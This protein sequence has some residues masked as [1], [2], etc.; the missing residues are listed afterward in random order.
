M[1][2]P[3]PSVVV[4][5]G[6]N[7]AGKST[8]APR[9]LGGSLRVWPFVNADTIAQGLSAFRPEDVA[10]DAG[11]IMLRRLDELEDQRKGFA[12]EAT[13]ASQALARRLARLKTRAYTV[14]I[15]FLWLPTPDLA[16]ARVAQ[17]VRAGGHDV[18]PDVVRR[19]FA[20]GLRNF[21]DLYR[22][23]VD[24]WRFYDGS[25]IRG[26]RLVASGG[27]GTETIV[28]DRENWRVA[29]G[30]CFDDREQVNDQ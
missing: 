18:P 17:R 15:V 22:P 16:I 30:E 20:R 8:S 6:P 9:L 13:L 28:R 19:R 11:R 1:A 10:L 5:G 29:F 4:L 7:G 3:S 26:P 21:F 23:T 2:P 14:H 25:S 27:I 24:K 12:F